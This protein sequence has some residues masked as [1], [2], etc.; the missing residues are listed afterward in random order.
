M[1]KSARL[2]REVASAMIGQTGPR[3][4][5]AAFTSA[6]RRKMIARSARIIEQL[7]I[8]RRKTQ[9][10]LDKIN[11]S[12][13]LEKRMYRDLIADTVDGP[14]DTPMPAAVDGE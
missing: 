12:I 7:K 6:D 1:S 13:T 10:V 9:A 8:K 3:K 4:P 2:H 5:G 14:I 11:D